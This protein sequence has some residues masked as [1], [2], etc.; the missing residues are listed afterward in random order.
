MSSHNLQNLYVRFLLKL[1]DQLNDL[2]R[3]TKYNDVTKR[4]LPIILNLWM[5]SCNFV[6]T[7][8]Y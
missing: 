3:Y 6:S 1:S 2:K 7:K 8:N 4:H 5:T